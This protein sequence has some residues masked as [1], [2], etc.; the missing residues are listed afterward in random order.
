MDEEFIEESCLREICNERNA[1]FD[2]MDMEVHSMD[3]H[4]TNTNPWMDE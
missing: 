3:I 1:Q 2:E 4:F